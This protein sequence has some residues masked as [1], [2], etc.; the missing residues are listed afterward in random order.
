MS[1]FSDIVTNEQTQIEKMFIGAVL[2]DG[3]NARL[4]AGWLEDDAIL[5]PKYREFWRR[6]RDGNDPIEVAAVMSLEEIYQYINLVPTVQK[7]GEIA[8]ALQSKSFLRLAVEDAKEIVRYAGDSDE[9]MILAVANRLANRSSGRGSE[10]RDPYDIAASLK[11]RILSGNLSIPFYISSLDRSTG[12]SERGTLTIIAAR[13]SMGKSSLMWQICEEQA[14]NG[15]L[16]VFYA[17]EMSA[18]QMYARRVCYKIGKTWL[19]VRN[20]N[21]TPEEEKDLLK[22]ID[23]YAEM[24]AEVGM[25]VSDSTSTTSADIIRN[26]LKYRFDV[27]A[28]DH[29]GLMK[30]RKLGDERHDQFIGRQ[31]E[32]LHSLAKNT[33]SVVYLLWQLNRKVEDRADKRPTMADL[34]DSGHLEQNADNVG[35]LYG[36]WYY[37]PEDTENIT[38]IFWSKYRDGTK[39]SMSFVEYD[40][41]SQ[42]FK[43]VDKKDIDTY[44]AENMEAI[45]EQ[46]MKMNDVGD[47]P[48]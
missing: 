13:P 32:G 7:V 35:L 10:L 14:I 12:G 29:G 42:Q 6:V 20:G 45:R 4:N 18:E 23:G 24:L 15:Y 46:Q 11:K 17:L 9:E 5:T 43:S 1:N 28:V 41:R 2:I 21:Y 19:D 40:M 36:N 26:Q 8:G 47:I 25:K 39:D 44:S 37:D 3:D 33:Q 22:Y 34:R 16:V 31:S 48:F 30:D 38:E 27:N